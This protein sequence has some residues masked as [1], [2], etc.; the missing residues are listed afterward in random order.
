MNGYE[1]EFAAGLCVAAIAIAAKEKRE[2]IIVPFNSNPVLQEMVRV[3]EKGVFY[4]WEGWDG[5]DNGTHWEEQKDQE[6]WAPAY[7]VFDQWASGGTNTNLAL[8][9]VLKN[10]MKITDAKPDLMLITDACFEHVEEGTLELIES[11]RESGMR[12]NGVTLNAGRLTDELAAFCDE[13][14]DITGLEEGF[15]SSTLHFIPQ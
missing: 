9:Y 10:I 6:A 4:K 11:R 8:E 7:A 3:D 5:P 2:V 14:T 12:F 1:H 15:T 13:V